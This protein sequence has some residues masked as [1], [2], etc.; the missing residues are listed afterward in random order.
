[1]T[2]EI[3]AAVQSAVVIQAGQIQ[4]GIHLPALRTPRPVP[5]QLPLAPRHFTDR[6]TEREALDAVRVGGTDVVVLSGIAGVGKSALAVQWLHGQDAYPD[7]QLYANL[8][9]RDGP[10]RPESVLQQW[11][12]AL[13]VEAFPADLHELTSVWR[14]VTAGRSVACL[15]DSART[16]DQVRPLLPAGSPSMTLVTSQRSLWELAVDGADLHQIGPFPTGAGVDLLARFAGED[17][18]AAEPDAAE[19]L[20]RVCGH[21]ALPLVLAG[22]RLRSRPHRRLSSLVDPLTPTTNARPHPEDFARM[23]TT[24]AL[25]KAYG[26]LEADA[27]RLYRQLAILPVEDID[28]DMAAA[29]A[30]IPLA[31]AGYLLDT[32][33]DEHLLEELAGD[34][35][36]PTRYRMGESQRDHARYLALHHDRDEARDDALQRLCAWMLAIAT[37]VQLRLSPAQATLRLKQGLVPEGVPERLPFDDDPGALAW[38]A[39]HQRNLPGIVRAARDHEWHE[40]AWQQVDAVWPLLHRRHPYDLWVELHELGVASA[41]QADNPAAVRQM[42][43]SGAIG[44]SQADR[45]STAIHWYTDALREARAPST[46]HD[47]DDAV[48]DEGQA[49]LGLGACYH[50]TGEHQKAIPLLTEAIQ[51]WTACDYPRGVALATIV[52]GEIATAQSDRAQA[53]ALFTRARDGLLAV[54]DQYDAD[55]ALAFHGHALTLNGD[56]DAGIRELTEAVEKL[57][58][59]GSTR[60]CARALDMLAGAHHGHGN[61][62]AA[63]RRYRQAADLMATIRPAYA[64][65]LRQRELAL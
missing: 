19:Q 13:G 43:L 63:R 41:R 38:L 32:L 56:V 57:G 30:S 62:D 51:L 25:N 6:S 26:D 55:R 54:G 16:A 11:L 35:A 52:L 36:R 47:K 59:H 61:L 64:E 10:V 33:T 20:V 58:A 8:S 34:E 65:H 5:R 9:G 44:L 37:Q 3:S 27:Q 2:N 12:H 15:L 17:R 50:D 42:L 24:A 21:L 22:A 31:T 49:L 45:W 29:V 4:G 18:V 40:A 23:A 7:G 46:A 1:M 39:S 60:M 14:S 28:P 48:R 53:L